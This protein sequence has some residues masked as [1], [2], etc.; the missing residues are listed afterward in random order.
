MSISTLFPGLPTG[1][2]RFEIRSSRS[3]SSVG[4]PPLDDIVDDEV[5][6]EEGCRLRAM[7]MGFA[8]RYL[9][10]LWCMPKRFF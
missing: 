9:F 2:D 8:R 4:A 1:V 6:E 3:E 7:R 5:E 10:W